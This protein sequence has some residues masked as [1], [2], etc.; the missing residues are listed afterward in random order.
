VP[1]LEHPWSRQRREHKSE[2]QSYGLPVSA[3]PGR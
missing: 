2:V 3:V 1:Q